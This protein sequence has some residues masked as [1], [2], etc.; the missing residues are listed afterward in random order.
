MENLRVGN[1]LEVSVNKYDDLLILDCDDL[2]I[3]QRF[4]SL[5]ENI[6][7]IAEEAKQEVERLQA[8]HKDSDEEDIEPVAAYVDLNIAFSQR[9]M[10][11]LDDT[12]GQGFTAKVFRENYELNPDFVPSEIAITDLIE[13]LAPV[14]EKAYGERIKRNKSKYNANK[15]GKHTKTKDELITEYKEKNDHE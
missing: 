4:V 14:M 6:Q 11:E 5:Y 8:Q 7:N 15:R 3:F 9:V 10:K 2:N 12:F 13:A 1:L